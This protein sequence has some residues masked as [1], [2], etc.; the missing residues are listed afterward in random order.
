MLVEAIPGGAFVENTYVIKGDRSTELILID[1]GSQIP[2]I[3]E[4]IKK[5]SFDK[6]YIV[7]T[8]AHLDHVYG[9]EHFKK[10]YDANF[11]LHKNELPI[12]DVMISASMRFGLEEFSDPVIP[13]VDFFIKDEEELEIAGLAFKAI[14]VPGHS[15]G[16]LC[17]YFQAQK[18]SEDNMEQDIV[19]SGDTVF[20]GSIG[21]VDLTGGTNMDDLVGNI[22]KRLMCLPGETILL[23]GHGPETRVSTEKESNPFLLGMLG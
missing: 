22:K 7:N 17:F 3:E 13:K 18:N 10:K 12:L 19:V 11:Y 20:A 23:P 6:M 5:I 14:L 21:R 16:S 4:V 2:E 1:P 9:V 8:H 15:P